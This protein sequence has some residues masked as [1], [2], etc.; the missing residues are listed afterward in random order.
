MWLLKIFFSILGFIFPLES[1]IRSPQVLRLV[2]LHEGLSGGFS[3]QSAFSSILSFRIAC[4][5]LIIKLFF[6][7]SVACSK[8]SCSIGRTFSRM[9]PPT[10]LVGFDSALIVYLASFSSLDAFS[11]WNP[12]RTSRLLIGEVRKAPVAVLKH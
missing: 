10:M 7:R 2:A 8:F 1:L 9:I 3:I 12:L 11:D 6:L 4:L 5:H